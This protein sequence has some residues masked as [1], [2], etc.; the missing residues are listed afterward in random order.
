MAPKMDESGKRQKMADLAE[1]HE[2]A[3]EKNATLEA[4][5]K[6]AKEKIETLQAQLAD[7]DR[8]IA[9]LKQMLLVELEEKKREIAELKRTTQ[10]MQSSSSSS[11]VGLLVA[12]P[13][14]PTDPLSIQTEVPEISLPLLLEDS[15]TS[16]K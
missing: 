11:D 14:R 8:M 12:A 10:E 7:K 5:L 1:E 4:E 6:A 15:P 13:S 9:E 16:G 3:L 2:L